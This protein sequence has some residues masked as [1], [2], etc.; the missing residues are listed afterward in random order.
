MT[1]IQEYLAAVFT[2]IGFHLR[3]FGYAWLAFL[4]V[5]LVAGI[6]GYSYFLAPPWDF[7]VGELVVIKSGES[8][9]DAANQL[10]ALQ[11]IRSPFLFH[12][13]VR[14]QSGTTG[15]HAGTYRFS[16]PQNLYT[17]AERL[18]AGQTGIA[19]LR[20]TFPEG[21]TA[22]DMSEKVA[23]LFPNISVQA[24]LKAAQPYEGYLFPDTYQF[25][26]SATAS[27]IVTTLR[28]NFDTQIASITPEVDASGH[29]LSDIVIM[30]SIVEKEARTQEDKRIVA[31][32]LWHRIALHMPLQV[33]AVFGYIYGRDTYSPSLEDL[34][35]DS[36]YNTYTHQGLPPGPIDNPGLDSIEAALHPT[37]TPYLYYL[38][39][40]DGAMHYA[41]TFE[42][43]Q[44]NRAAYLN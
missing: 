9:V 3:R 36:P 24:F 40:S 29:T 14:L 39:G 42:E 33:D 18:I 26:P 21:Q 28:T 32:I 11:V 5:C 41:K 8:V 43:H 2:G 35:V 44:A 23:A 12:A 38:T 30:A 17:V 4:S 31:G 15:V 13:L 7:P 10:A 19:D 27:T 34:S 37:K 6:V 1:D 16:T 20:I 25:A 22:Q